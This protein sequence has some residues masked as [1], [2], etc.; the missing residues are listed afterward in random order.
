MFG[1]N[2]SRRRRDSSKL[3]CFI[4]FKSQSE[5]R[6]KLS[7]FGEK[8]FSTLEMAHQRRLFD[9][10]TTNRGWLMKRYVI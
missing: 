7:G 10:L 4:T 3:M 9:A 1:G 2:E 8:I 5:R 6:R